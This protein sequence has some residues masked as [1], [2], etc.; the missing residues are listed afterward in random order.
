MPDVS[1]DK[2]RSRGKILPVDLRACC[3]SG[4]KRWSEQQPLR[5]DFM[6]PNWNSPMLI[7]GSER[8][9]TGLVSG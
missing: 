3:F 1:A 6:L 9:R 5:T 2:D 7:G 8:Q 4:K